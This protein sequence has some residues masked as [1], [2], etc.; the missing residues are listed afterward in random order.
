MYLASDSTVLCIVLCDVG[1][2]QNL[3]PVLWSPTTIVAECDYNILLQ[4][5]ATRKYKPFQ[6]FTPF[7]L[8]LT[9]NAVTKFVRLLKFSSR[10]SSGR[11]SPK[12][13]KF[14][15]IFVMVQN[16]QPIFATLQDTCKR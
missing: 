4:L 11:K 2:Q 5:L 3:L 12:P 7:F 10:N 8:R 13:P 6:Q 14:D 1:F 16:Q 15:Q 9:Q